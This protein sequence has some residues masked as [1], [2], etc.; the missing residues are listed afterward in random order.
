MK[1]DIALHRDQRRL[2]IAKFDALPEDNPL[3]E[4]Y[5]DWIRRLDEIIAGAGLP[6]QN[7][8]SNASVTNTGQLNRVS[9]LP[10]GRICVHG[11]TSQSLVSPIRPI[12]LTNSKAAKQPENAAAPQ[13]AKANPEKNFGKSSSEKEVVFGSQ[14]QTLKD[15]LISENRLLKCMLARFG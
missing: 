8:K 3:R 5:R 14:A 11:A 4:R 2:A 6:T 7:G 1:F 9:D 13:D 15:R 10:A 12:G